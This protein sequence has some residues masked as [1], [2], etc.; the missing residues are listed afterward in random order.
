MCDCALRACGPKKRKCKKKGVSF[1]ASN[2]WFRTPHITTLKY[3]KRS[4]LFFKKYV[5][6]RLRQDDREDDT[7]KYAPGTPGRNA[8]GCAVESADSD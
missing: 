3:Y 6:A 4:K 8:T 1:L 7:C 2:T 5:S